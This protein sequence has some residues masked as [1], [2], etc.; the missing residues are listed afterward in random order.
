MEISTPLIV[1]FVGS[2]LLLGIL[3]LTAFVKL[4]VVFMILRNALGLQQ[5]PSNMIVMTLTLFLAVFISIPVISQSLSSLASV[6]FDND[7]LPELVTA[8]SNALEPFQT[9]IV[10]NTDP[11]QLTFFVEMANSVWQGSGFVGSV[12]DIFIQIPAFLVSELTHAFEMG[13]LIY[14]PF[15][16]VD[17]AVTVILMATGM[18]Q[19]QPTIISTPFKLLLFVSLNGWTKMIEG[20]VLSYGTVA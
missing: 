16:A 14:L 4:S 6:N 8:L 17:L 15:I 3:T 5:V 9:F 12:E 18:Q 1:G 7:S 10:R 13:F 2:F 20:L 11:N 19:V